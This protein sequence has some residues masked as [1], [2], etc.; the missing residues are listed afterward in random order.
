MGA[1][2]L[3]CLVS[4]LAW[5]GAGL[6]LVEG[7]GTL[8]SLRLGVKEK[9]RVAKGAVWWAGGAGGC[10]PCGLGVSSLL[11]LTAAL[12]AVMQVMVVARG[13]GLGCC[14]VA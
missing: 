9:G 13:F 2:S 5:G 6:A 11:R 7:G 12:G 8:G 10:C 14:G 4:D 3:M 1:S